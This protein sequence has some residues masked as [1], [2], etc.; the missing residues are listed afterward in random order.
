MAWTRAS[1]EYPDMLGSD[2]WSR[3]PCCSAR[4]WRSKVV[5][6]MESFLI[7]GRLDLDLCA[8]QIIIKHTV[9]FL[10]AVGHLESSQDRFLILAEGHVWHHFHWH[11]GQLTL[12]WIS[13]RLKYIFF[14]KGANSVP[15]ENRQFWHVKSYTLQHGLSPL[16]FFPFKI[17]KWSNKGTTW[18]PKSPKCAGKTICPAQSV[19]QRPNIATKIT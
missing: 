6:F 1:G 3:H 14:I 12:R 11:H 17:S 19:E 16:S 9:L 2:L 10:D 7:S 18:L 8:F 5:G 13:E 15:C 4:S